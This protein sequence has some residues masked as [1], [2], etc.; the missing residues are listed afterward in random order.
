MPQVQS[1][2]QV[3]VMHARAMPAGMN[4]VSLRRLHRND[5]LAQCNAMR[6]R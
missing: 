3:Q 4:A 6:A 5:S 2:Q 1:L